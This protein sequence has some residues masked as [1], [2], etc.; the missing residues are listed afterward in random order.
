VPW[1][2]A[3]HVAVGTSIFLIIAGGAVS[4]DLLVAW[5]EKKYTITSEVAQG[6]K[7]ASSSIFVTDLL[8][9]FVCLAKTAYRT[10]KKL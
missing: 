9:L 7:L 8:V 4:I 6:L 2:F 5:V 3:V 10:M 1:E